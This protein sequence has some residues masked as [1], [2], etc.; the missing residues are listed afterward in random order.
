MWQKIKDRFTRKIYIKKEESHINFTGLKVIAYRKGEKIEQVL[1][2]AGISKYDHK[3]IRPIYTD[4][5]EDE[6]LTG[7]VLK[8]KTLFVER[9]G[10]SL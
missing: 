2:P 6:V 1:Y 10:L 8:L 3:L 7:Y 4:L 5:T 9:E